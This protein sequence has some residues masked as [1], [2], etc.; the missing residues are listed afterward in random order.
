MVRFILL[1]LIN[2]NIHFLINA[3]HNTMLHHTVFTF[4]IFDKHY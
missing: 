1:L 3:K 2:T 4:N